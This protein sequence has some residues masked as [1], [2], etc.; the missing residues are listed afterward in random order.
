METVNSLTSAASRAIWGEQNK[1]TDATQ[2]GAANQ[3][4]ISGETGDVNAGEP[5]D[6]G[7]VGEFTS[8]ELGFGSESFLNSG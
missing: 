7:N 4:P 8:R 2:N 1:D 5:Y 3:E 6:K